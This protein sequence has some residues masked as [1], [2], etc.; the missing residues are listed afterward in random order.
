MHHCGNAYHRNQ[1]LTGH[2]NTHSRRMK[3]NRQLWQ[4][5]YSREKFPAM[6]CPT[7]SAGH[8][9]M[10]ASSLLV[11]EPKYSSEF[12]SHDAWEP[13]WSIERFICFLTCDNADCGEY[14]A[15]AGE[16][17]TVE[18]QDEEYGWAYEGRLL[19]RSIIP[20]PLIFD[21]PP[22][23]PDVLKPIIISAFELYWLDMNA[24]A[25]KIR[26]SVEALLT[27][28]GIP[29]EAKKANGDLYRIFLADRIAK[30]KELHSEHGETMD[31][32]RYVGNVGS[33]EDEISREILL[34]A[35]EIYED[36]L[37]E[38]YGRRSERLAA[39]KAKIIQSKGKYST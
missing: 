14:A 28:L 17:K 5:T 36:A 22:E 21:L 30:F 11:K 24:C 31:A 1:T 34:D 38:L 20:A 26:A 19:P 15:V 32:L 39:I 18:I 25:N 10:N 7:C 33:H 16:I 29:A 4:E 9:Q 6:K 3:L 27:D 37:H 12:H 8:Y 23:L 13:D 2:L 35:F